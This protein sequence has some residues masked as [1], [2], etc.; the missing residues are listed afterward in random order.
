MAAMFADVIMSAIL[1]GSDVI[2]GLGDWYRGEELLLVQKSNILS[3]LYIGTVFRTNT[4][5]QKC[6][7]YS[8]LQTSL[9]K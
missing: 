6:E 4:L 5:S 8:V 9:R 7:V 1:Y 2:V 3:V